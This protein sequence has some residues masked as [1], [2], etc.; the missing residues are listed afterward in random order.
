MKTLFKTIFMISTTFTG[1]NALSQTT[2]P[3]QWTPEMQVK[4]Y[5]HTASPNPSDTV[6]IG[7]ESFRES[8]VDS[9]M[10]KKKLKISP[11]DLNDILA[12]F[13]KYKLTEIRPTPSMVPVHDGWTH[14]L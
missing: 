10:G 4:I 3:T 11:K 1:G 2:G 5:S 8:Y 13:N 14:F 12:T 6:T 9:R 7:T